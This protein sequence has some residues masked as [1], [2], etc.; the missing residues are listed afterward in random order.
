MVK[1]ILN[2]HNP[3]PPKKKQNKTK[4]NIRSFREIFFVFYL[5]NVLLFGLKILV[6]GDLG[7]SSYLFIMISL[8]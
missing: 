1:Y 3:P 2:K 7:V 8:S 4:K 6:F 5:L